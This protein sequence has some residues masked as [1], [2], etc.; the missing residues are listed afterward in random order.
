[1]ALHGVQV[2][3]YRRD[4][5]GMEEALRLLRPAV[6]GAGG[7]V[8]LLGGPGVLDIG[9]VTVRSGSGRSVSG[10]ASGRRPAGSSRR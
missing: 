4:A 6:R 3:A 8:L 7:V 1:L 9:P 2:D 10:A 5:Q